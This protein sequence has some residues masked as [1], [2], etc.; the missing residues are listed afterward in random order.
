MTLVLVFFLHKY[1]S[2][3]LPLFITLFGVAV[4]GKA[5]RKILK[6]VSPYSEKVRYVSD[7]NLG[8]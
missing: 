2:I 1:M 6:F 8:K 7:F 4:R 5:K 3:V